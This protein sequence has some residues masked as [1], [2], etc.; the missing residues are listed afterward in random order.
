MRIL[1]HWLES[2][3]FKQWKRLMPLLPGRSA[4]C[5]WRA[6]DGL[7]WP[8]VTTCG[9]CRSQRDKPSM[10]YRT[11]DGLS[12]ERWSG[13]VNLKHRSLQERELVHIH[14]RKKYYYF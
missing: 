13:G 14:G 1:R 12:V 4:S 5:R 7:Q 11:S 10:E 6:V 3:P 2:L 9:Q 8:L